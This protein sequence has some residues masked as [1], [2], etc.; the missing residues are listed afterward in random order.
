MTPA[1]SSNRQASAFAI[2]L[3]ILLGL[4]A[5]TARTGVFAR[6]EVYPAIPWKYGPFPWIQQK[7]FDESKDVDIAFLGSS[8]IWCAINTPFV[9]QHLSGQLGRESEVFTL[10]W[11][12]TGFDALYVI[13]RDLLE[14][15]RVRM[16]VIYDEN[17]GTDE[18]H[19][20][21]SRWFRA[22]DSDVLSGL[23]WE[24]QASL[25]GGAVLGIPRQLLSV[26]RPDLLEDPAHCHTNFWNNYYHAPN[27]AENLGSLR[28]RLAYGVSPN[29][30]PFQPKGDATPANAL[31]YSPETRG[32]FEFNGR[33]MPPYQLH[34]AR[35]LAELCRTRGTHLVVIH[36]PSLDEAQ[37]TIISERQNWQAVLGSEITIIG[38]PP[39]RLFAGIPLEDLPR[40]FY[41]NAHLNQNGQDMF[42]ALITPKL[43]ELYNAPS[44]IH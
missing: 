41:E 11:P 13:A 19:P 16:M 25:Y 39:S 26:L 2:L 21:S 6:R 40:L 23:P 28:A 8:H 17:R 3:A 15:R 9:Q 5:L 12:W 1:F 10:S 14:H 42:T 33:A 4:P 30:V 18:P 44:N 32:S 36:T 43:I 34:F 24:S 37:E 31:E 35:K 29:F 7:I 22:G 27:L 20:Q 38:I